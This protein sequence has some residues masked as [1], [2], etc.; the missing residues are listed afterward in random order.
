MLPL[1]RN[2]IMQAALL[3]HEGAGL[4]TVPY[5][6]IRRVC[7]VMQTDCARVL[8]RTGYVP[9]SVSMILWGEAVESAPSNALVANG[10]TPEQV[11]G[12]AVGRT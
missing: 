6:R 1:T 10:A 9:S 12:W 11:A 8:V 4:S 7:V 3:R 5:H 2:R